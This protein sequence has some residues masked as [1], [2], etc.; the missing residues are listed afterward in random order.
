VD[1]RKANDHKCSRKEVIKMANISTKS[2]R[3]SRDVQKWEQTILHKPESNIHFRVMA[4]LYKF[5]DLLLPRKRI[6]KEADIRPGFHILDYGCGPRSCLIPLAELA[7]KSGKIYLLDAH[8]LAIQ[9]VEK[10]ACRKRLTNVQT[11]LSDCKTGLASN[12]M[13][14]VLLYDT[15]HDLRDQNGVL[16]ELHRILKPNGILSF[17]DH[18]MKESAIISGVTGRGLFRLLKKG[19]RTFSFSKAD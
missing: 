5:R 9:M 18:H 10:T 15:F 4:L 6:L 11:I 7:G 12:S 19:K 1:W 17:S 3:D 14:T 8:P 2:A 16:E 13:D